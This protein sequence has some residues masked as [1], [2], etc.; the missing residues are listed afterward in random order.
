MSSRLFLAF[1]VMLCLGAPSL[2]DDTERAN[3]LFVAAVR[4]WNEATALTGDD[5]TTIEARAALLGKVMNNLNQIVDDHSGSELAVQLV[6]G[7]QVGPL[8]IS[9]TTTALDS[10]NVDMDMAHCFEAPTQNCV[11]ASAIQANLSLDSRYH[12]EVL[13]NIA[14]S[15]ARNGR[16]EKVES[17]LGVVHP[18]DM[19]SGDLLKLGTALNQPEMF[20]EALRV[21]LAQHNES[22]K[23]SSVINVIEALADA[24]MMEKA[25]ETMR[26]LSKKSDVARALSNTVGVLAEKRELEAAI[27]LSKSIDDLNYRSGAQAEIVAAQVN[28]G[29]LAEAETTAH[30]IE[31][32]YHQSW[33]L[34]DIGVARKDAA[35][36]QQALSASESEPN[37]LRHLAVS[38]AAQALAEIGMLQEARR[39][40]AQLESA[41]DTNAFLRGVAGDQAEAGEL[42][43]AY[44]TLQYITDPD[45]V[46][47]AL[48]AIAVGQA[49]A[50]QDETALT[51]AIGLQSDF[52]RVNAQCDIALVKAEVGEVTKALHILRRVDPS[53]SCR[54]ETLGAIS[55]IL[56]S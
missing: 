20:D 14:V 23:I 34:M 51:T 44:A 11:F 32:K 13:S 49:K 25:F 43:Q 53:F 21:A 16:N 45:E 39:V 35:M 41:S 36:I 8:S 31:D 50:G 42:H 28:A 46:E 47:W 27:E 22:F 33:A 56:D 52:L 12:V 19:S 1:L 15:M 7:E 55:A 48:R 5:L 18:S 17:I 54:P 37:Q 26:H 40:I 2:A 10:A 38:R 4:S 24:G 30:A 9:G 29:L 3:R 6:T